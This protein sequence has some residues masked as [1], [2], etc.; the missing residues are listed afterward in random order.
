MKKMKM[1]CV[2]LIALFAVT[3]LFAQDS[4]FGTGTNLAEVLFSANP[5]GKRTIT[6]A[7][8]ASDKTGSLLKFYGRTGVGKLYPTAAPTNGAQVI[9]VNNTG[10]LITTNDIVVYQYGDGGTNSSGLSSFK[11]TLSA[12]STGTITLATGIGQTGSTNDMVYKMGQQFQA[13]VGTTPLNTA[14]YLIYAAPTDSPIYGTLD[15]NTS[16]VLS[17]ASTFN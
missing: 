3:P 1:L 15:A 17:A 4:K 9:S 11:T 16:A 7:Y 14:G 5:Y 6:S 13:T 8:A 2:L 12:N 10:N